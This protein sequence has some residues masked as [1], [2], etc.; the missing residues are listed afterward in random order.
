[1]GTN[2]NLWA[3]SLRSPIRRLRRL[4]LVGW[5]GVGREEFRRTSRRKERTSPQAQRLRVASYGIDLEGTGVIARVRSKTGGVV[6]KA[7]EIEKRYERLGKRNGA[8]CV[9]AT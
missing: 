9:P 8:R 2:L 6:A 5:T 4:A 7:K 3:G 1:M